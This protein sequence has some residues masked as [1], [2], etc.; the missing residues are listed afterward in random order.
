MKR[1][2]SVS[3]SST[4]TGTGLA[5][6]VA[7]SLA[8]GATVAAEIVHLNNGD[9]IHGSIVAANNE[10]VTLETPYG[11]LVI[12]KSDIARIDYQGGEA[13]GTTSGGSPIANADEAD[14][15]VGRT[16]GEE[17][18]ESNLDRWRSRFPSGAA[19]I[20]LQISG[21][22][23]WY[24]FDSPPDRPSDT[25][26]RLHLYVGDEKACTFLDDKPDTVDGNT[27]YNSFTLSPT[28]SQIV[29]TLGGF[30][31]RVDKA[32]D[33]EVVLRVSVPPASSAGR[34]TVRMLYEVNEG[35]PTLPRWLDAVSRSFSVELTPGRETLV[36]LEQN[37]DALEYTGFFKKSMKNLELF[38]LNVLSTELR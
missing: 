12:P 31:C 7:L 20:A 9:A 37:A 23:F 6:L 15:A 4:P 25:R 3:V 26:I 27:L 33:G 11:K 24:A 34:Q 30:D 36:R 22:S 18:R 35:D 21:R 16:E 32:D 19:R 14:G 29:E 1:T 5:V 10:G 2:Q 13:P 8:A 38:Q 28:E 17:G